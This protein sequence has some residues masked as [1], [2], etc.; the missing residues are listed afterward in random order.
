MI[1]H[2]P[3]IIIY[4]TQ[5]STTF[6]EVDF[7]VVSVELDDQLL[8]CNYAVKSITSTKYNNVARWTVM[9]NFF[10]IYQSYLFQR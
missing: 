4:S 3:L 10:Y 6:L 7:L 8:L 5:I 2:C 9:S 1:V